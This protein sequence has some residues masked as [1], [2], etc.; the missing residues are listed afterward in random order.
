M[1]THRRA[2]ANSWC[3]PE[4]RWKFRKFGELP[5]RAGRRTGESRAAGPA[6]LSDDR[7]SAMNP[8]FP[9]ID[10]ATEFSPSHRPRASPRRPPFRRHGFPRSHGPAKSIVNRQGLTS[11]ERRAQAVL[12]ARAD[13]RA[14]FDVAADSG[15]NPELTQIAAAP[16]QGPGTFRAPRAVPARPRENSADLVA[17]RGCPLVLPRAAGACAQVATSRISNEWPGR[18]LEN[19]EI[20]KLSAPGPV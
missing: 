14:H 11:P 1:V 20:R 13:R 8:K 15:Q 16:G 9:P 12:D 6:F 7:G 18:S 5:Q 4:I 19:P 3:G 17:R 2:G 10:A